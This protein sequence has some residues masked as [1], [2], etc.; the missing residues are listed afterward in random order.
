[1][2]RSAFIYLCTVIWTQNYFNLDCTAV[3][4]STFYSF[5]FS[6]LPFQ[7]WIIYGDGSFGYSLIEFDTYTRHKTP[8]I[9]LVGND[10]GWTQIAREQVPVFGSSI[11]CDLAVGSPVYIMTV[12]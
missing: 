7:V 3:E 8:V 6:I 12:L 9:A 1:M 11:G 4:T 5:N 2:W 10:A